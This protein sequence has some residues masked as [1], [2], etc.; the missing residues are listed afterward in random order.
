MA[1]VTVIV[2]SFLTTD[3][4]TGSVLKATT[5]SVEK[6]KHHTVR[7]AKHLDQIYSPKLAGD[8]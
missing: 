3:S 8:F 4:T 5:Q 1:T 7:D 2:H 6:A